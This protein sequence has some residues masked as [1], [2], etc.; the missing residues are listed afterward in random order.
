[1]RNGQLKAGYNIQLAVNN[2]Y[3]A[4]V[5]VM[6]SR[7]DHKTFEPFMNKFFL[8]HNLYPKYPVAD[9]GYGSYDNYYFCKMNGME[10]YQKYGMWSKESTRKFQKNIY[11]QQNLQLLDNG[12]YLCPNNKELVLE[13]E[14][15]SKRLQYPNQIKRFICREC[16]K[17]SLKSECTKAKGNREIHVNEAFNDFKQE[18]KKNLSSHL[19]IELRIQRS[20]QV[21]GAFGV[22]KEDMKF[23]R[24]TRIS[25]TN[26]LLEVSL[27]AIGY[28]LR[29]FHRKKH[30]ENFIIH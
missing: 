7:S 17:C 23:R 15:T 24:F 16:S 27:I 19:G 26:V 2:E 21:E 22:I 5:D 4:C 25:K 9:A 8:L 6:A 1:M 10:L 11:H 14:Y 12:N 29:K 3:I 13:R 28:N 18:V 20:I 30:R